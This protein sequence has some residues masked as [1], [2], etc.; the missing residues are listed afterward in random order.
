MG[1]ASIVLGILALLAAFG[2]FITSFIPFVGPFVGAFLSFASPVLGLLGVIFGGVALSR[3]KDEGGDTGAATAGLVVS[4]IGFFLGFLVA[5]SCGVCSTMCAGAMVQGSHGSKSPPIWWLDGGMPAAS[6]GPAPSPGVQP[7][8][9][10]AQPQPPGTPNAQ[11]L[12]PATPP[13]PS[14]PPPAFPPPPVDPSP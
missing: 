12:A 8:A 9:P 11:P 4:G 14:A 7:G 13:D 5:I 3:A 2:G 6:P 10:N 1:A